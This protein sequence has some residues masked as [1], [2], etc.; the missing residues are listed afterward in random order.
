M[1][2]YTN[3]IFSDYPTLSSISPLLPDLKLNWNLFMVIIYTT[4][5][6][7]IEQPGTYK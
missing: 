2:A 4:Y 5:Y 3:S 6:A 1:L 7:L